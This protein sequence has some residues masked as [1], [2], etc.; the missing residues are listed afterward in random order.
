MQRTTGESTFTV[1]CAWCS[2][3]TSPGAGTRVSHGICTRCRRR[4]LR[5]FGVITQF[6]DGGPA[7][8]LG[9]IEDRGFELLRPSDE[10]I[11]LQ[12]SAIRHVDDEAVTLACDEETL[13]NYIA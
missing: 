8:V 12:F 9:R 7:G 6:V 4:V 10:V 5:Q 13:S 11:W 3:I 2:S 1:I